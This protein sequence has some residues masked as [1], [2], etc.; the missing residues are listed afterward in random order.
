MLSAVTHHLPTVQSLD[1]SQFDDFTT[2]HKARA[3]QILREAKRFV[4]NLTLKQS[5]AEV[6]KREAITDLSVW[7]AAY[8]LWQQIR[9]GKPHSEKQL[10]QVLQGYESDQGWTARAAHELITNA[11]DTYHTERID[12]HA[13][14]FAV[15]LF[16]PFEAGIYAEVVPQVAQGKLSLADAALQVEHKEAGT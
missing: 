5:I 1:W 7:A 16:E 4:A 12:R 11:I 14:E 9:D 3:V 13:A 8:A 15:G 10:W 6:A 2:P